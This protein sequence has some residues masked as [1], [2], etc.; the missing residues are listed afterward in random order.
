MSCGFP[1]GAGF[2]L[3]LEWET[4]HDRPT[5]IHFRPQIQKK[6]LDIKDTGKMIQHDRGKRGPPGKSNVISGGL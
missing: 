4:A 5:N 6:S 2:L 3:D 1:F